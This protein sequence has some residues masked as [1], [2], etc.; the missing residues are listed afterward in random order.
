MSIQ[1]KGTHSNP[2][3]DTRRDVQELIRH[4]LDGNETDE[5]R[6]NAIDIPLTA[7]VCDGKILP[8]QM[9]YTTKRILT[10]IQRQCSLVCVGRENTW[11]DLLIRPF[12]AKQ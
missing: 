1:S 8:N 4:L 6:R 9:K 3:V 7:I 11:S 2:L 5:N 12:M 10:A